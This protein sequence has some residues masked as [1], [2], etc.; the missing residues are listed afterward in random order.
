MVKVLMVCSN[1]LAGAPGNIPGTKKGGWY[2]EECAHPYV[3]FEKAGYEIELCS[4]KGGDIT[5]VVD[6]DSIGD[7]DKDPVKKTLWESDAFQAKCK[8]TKPLSSY[9]GTDYNIFFLVGGFGVMWDFFPNPAI[10]RVGKECY[11]SG[12]IVGA[13]C[14]GP[15]GL[16]SITLSNGEPLVKGKNVGGFANFE[17]D[18]VKIKIPL[19]A[20]FDDKESCEDIL[21]ALG[22]KHTHSEKPFGVHVTVDER[23]VCGQNPP[24]ADP[25]G[26]AIV[27]LA[28]EQPWGA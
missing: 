2:L 14:H 27:E 28:K 8:D 17:E 24:S 25:C 12:G 9:T 22:G 11:E 4:I 6:P 5:G 19:H 18:I 13:V 7:L 15:I 26:E 20:G 3:Q 23:V 1:S 21:T 16:A 10:G